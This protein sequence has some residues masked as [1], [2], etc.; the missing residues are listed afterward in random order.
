MIVQE[1]TSPLMEL[2]A[3]IQAAYTEKMQY[4]PVLAE[5][6]KYLLPEAKEMVVTRQTSKGQIHTVKTFTA[7]PALAANRMGAGV[8]AYLM[9]VGQ[10]W[11]TVKASEEEQNELLEV[12]QWL[13][14]FRIKVHQ[15]L[16]ESNYQREM[17]SCIRNLC[18]FGTACIS[19]MWDDGLLFE[20][21]AL[22]TIAFE[23]NHKGIIDTV[24][25]TK[26]MT[27]RQATGQFGDI[28]L[29]KSIDVERALRPYSPKLFEFVHCVYPNDKYNQFKIGSFPFASVWVNKSDKKVV[30]V[31]GYYEQPYIVVRFTTIP[32]ETMGRSPAHALLPEIKMYD[33]MRRTF[34]ESA[35]RAHNPPWYV[36]SESIIGQPITSPGAIIY[37]HPHGDPPIPLTTG[38]N[39]QL[40]AEMLAQTAEIIERGFFND[41]FDALALHRN[42]TATEVE[43]RL[44][45]KMVLL[46]PAINGQKG[47]L[48]DPVIM[49]VGSL[50]IRHNQL[51]FKPEGLKT[52]IIYTG[53]LAM[54]MSTMQSNALGAVM[55]KWAPYLEVHPVYDNIDMDK[56]FKHD[57]R[58]HGVP[59]TLLVDKVRVQGVRDKRNGMSMAEPGSKVMEKA[60]KAYKNIYD[61]GGIDN[62]V[63]SVGV[64]A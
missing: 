23:V 26:W 59:E 35:E 47:E 12:K 18:I 61:A 27:C 24:F 58:A 13:S 28:S 29:G 55:A 21:Y 3:R 51:P 36:S 8:Y 7:V 39:S 1:R 19:V 37:G 20:N 38:I 40:N 4:A 2:L 62:L 22:N 56:A 43:A 33:R 11:F 34:I 46:S 57:A 48:T 17:F 30:K 14:L 54:A 41:L 45:E 6:A 63:N 52:E 64:I 31:G 9:P 25:R 16:W 32:G 42:M 10:H 15:A 53:R 49:R 60:S 5:I 50:L 44:E